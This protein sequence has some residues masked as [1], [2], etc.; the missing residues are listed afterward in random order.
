MTRAVAMGLLTPSLLAEVKTRKYENV[1]ANKGIL[2]IVLTLLAFPAVYFAGNWVHSQFYSKNDYF[3]G[4]AGDP[5]NLPMGGAGV[6]L[7]PTFERQP[8]ATLS[9]TVIATHTPKP[10]HVPSDFGVSVKVHA[11]QTAKALANPKR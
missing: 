8:L 9:P 10:T 3:A 4:K 2:S 6:P 7:R 5:N 11:T 1:I